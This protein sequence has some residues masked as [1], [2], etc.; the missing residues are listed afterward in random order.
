MLVSVRYLAL[1]SEAKDQLADLTMKLYG[2]YRS[3][4]SYR[5]RIILNI[6]GIEWEYVSVRLDKGEQMSP[7]HLARNPLK[8]VPVLDTG[9]ALL[10]QSVAIAEFLETRFPEPALL[11][12]GDIEKARVREL[13]QVI[14][15]D[16]QPIANLRVLK[17][18]R[19]NFGV[20]DAGVDDW[21]CTWIGKGFEAFEKRASEW[22]T[23]GQF[24][25]GD[26]ISVADAFLMPQAY[27]ADRFGLDMTPFPTIRSIV[28]HCSTL[29]P[30]ARAHPSLQ[31][32]SPVD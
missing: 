16:I 15:S 28:A 17:H 6:K 11:P 25:F 27:N 32:D 21:A 10:A 13:V 14:A 8:L 7:E 26:R 30:V 4:A 22:S 18:I 9:D 3:S 5:I 29:E 2:Y 12:S 1:S 24:A 20:D 23:D 19:A 31:P